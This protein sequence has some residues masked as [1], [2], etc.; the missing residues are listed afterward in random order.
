MYINLFSGWPQHARRSVFQTLTRKVIYLRGKLFAWTDVW[1]NTLRSMSQWERNWRKSLCRNR[2]LLHQAK[3]SCSFPFC[4]GRWY[5]LCNKRDGRFQPMEGQLGGKKNMWFWICQVMDL[6]M[7]PPSMY[8]GYVSSRVYS[9]LALVSNICFYVN[10]KL[11][12][13]VM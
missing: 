8:H 6:T 10:F 1:Q 3:A 11:D 4:W 13:I 7:L 9:R 2:Q 12:C 5:L